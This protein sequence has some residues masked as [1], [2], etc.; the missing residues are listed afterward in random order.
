MMTGALVTSAKGLP[1]SVDSYVSCYSPVG[2]GPARAPKSKAA[3]NDGL[4]ANERD[5]A[6]EETGV[7][8]GSNPRHWHVTG[9]KPTFC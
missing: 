8:R 9:G 7:R 5:L 4:M 2:V 6:E 3:L 1:E